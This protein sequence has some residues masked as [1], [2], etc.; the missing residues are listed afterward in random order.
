MNRVSL[1][2]FTNKCLD[3]ICSWKIFSN[4]GFRIGFKIRNALPDGA[5]CASV[6]GLVWEWWSL[7]VLHLLQQKRNMNPWSQPEKC[8]GRESKWR[9]CGWG[10][11]CCTFLHIAALRFLIINSTPF[12][13]RVRAVHCEY[14]P[15]L[16][17]NA[18]GNAELKT[19]LT[20]IFL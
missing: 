15:I 19:F 2:N 7:W 14:Q 10:W 9:N 17:A 4:T 6:A 18:P 12:P 16:A 1:F 8:T 13:S 3:R 20:L 5:I 11:K